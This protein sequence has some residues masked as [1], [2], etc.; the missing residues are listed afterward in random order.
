M[1]KRPNYVEEVNGVIQKLFCQVCGDQIAGVSASPIGSGPY[2]NKLSDSFKRFA[3]YAEIKIEFDDGSMHVTNGCKKC[4]KMTMPIEQANEIYQADLS[5]MGLKQD[6][7]VPV[8][9]V[10]VD[11]TGVGLV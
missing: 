4:L 7:R 1:L 3:N 10:A 6:N 8:R 9:I 2:A 5:V 11:T